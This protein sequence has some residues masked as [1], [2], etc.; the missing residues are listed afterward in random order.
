[1]LPYYSTK[2]IDF[3]KISTLQRFFQLKVEMEWGG[4]PPC[5]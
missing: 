2:Q 4:G 3:L 1:M 5:T